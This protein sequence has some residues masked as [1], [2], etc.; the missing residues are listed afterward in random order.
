MSAA[1]APRPAVSVV[2]AFRDRELERARR[3]LD[4]LAGQ[5]VGDLEVLFVDSGSA[6]A[7]REPLRRLVEAAGGRYLHS[8][9]RGHPW[10]RAQALNAGARRATGRFLTTTDVDLVF[11]PRF[12]E[13]V[14]AAAAEDRVVYVAP[15]ML[16]RGFAG[17]DDLAAGARHPA[18]RRGI[19]YG[20]CQVVASEVFARLGGFD[21][22]YRYWGVEDRD[23]HRRLLAV[24]LTEVWLDDAP[25]PLHQW[26]P[27]A[28]VKTPGSLPVGLWGRMELHFLRH[29]GDVV[30]NGDGWGRLLTAA[31]RPALAFVDD[32]A[33]RLAARPD[34]HRFTADPYSPRSIGALLA[35]F[36]ELP[37]GA[38]L[39]VGGAALP[40]RRAAADLLLR[41]VRRPLRTAGSALDYRSN[42]LHGFVAELAHRKPPEL[43]DY[44][45]DLPADDG[46]SVLVRGGGDGPR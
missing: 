6:P 25:R 10:N 29:Q 26:H 15:A 19:G 35:A 14:L 11:P 32:E 12:F 30:R 18:A 38:A 41:A 45:L 33:G 17:W 34:L 37:P 8:E 7:L 44:Y 3:F 40:R 23:L 43:L 4:S 16:P 28:D 22:Y 27:P 9:T 13:A 39:A 1:P 46:V 42:V 31:D 5:S 24:G 21:E 2:V 36:W 20:G